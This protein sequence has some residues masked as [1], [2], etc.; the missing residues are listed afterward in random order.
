MARNNFIIQLP[1]FCGFNESLLYNSDSFDNEVSDSQ[2]LE[3]YRDLFNDDTITGEDLE[4]DLKAYR[5]YLCD[6]FIGHFFSSVDCPSFITDICYYSL[7]YG[8]KLYARITLDSYWQTNIKSYMKLYRDKIAE[9]IHEDFGRDGNANGISFI[10][11]SFDEWCKEIFTDRPNDIYISYIIKYIMLIK[12]P[13]IG[14]KLIEETF[15]D[16]K[17]MYKFVYVKNAGKIWKSRD[18]LV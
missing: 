18:W 6:K 12:A 10:S 2:N 4:L 1:F 7:S 11:D 5:R 13:N 8:D 15:N 14:D 3:Y 16:T 9:F 17:D